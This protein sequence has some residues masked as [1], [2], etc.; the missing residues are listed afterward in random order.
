[1]TRGQIS[2]LQDLNK[3]TGLG[4]FFGAWVTAMYALGYH[5][6]SLTLCK[7]E[8]AWLRRLT[9]QYAGQIRA[10]RKNQVSA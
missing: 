10:M 1:M 4:D 3:C 6:K 8:K 5:D 2:Q 7:L 9:H